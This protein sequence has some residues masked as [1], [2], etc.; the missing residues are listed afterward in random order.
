M[1]ITATMAKDYDDDDT[2]ENG[3]EADDKWGL[4]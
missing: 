2:D 3:S 1:M 4:R